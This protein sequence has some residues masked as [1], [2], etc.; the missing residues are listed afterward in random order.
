MLR[1]E[2]I[3]ISVTNR[4]KK[5]FENLG[6]SIKEDKL[7]IKTI[8]LSVNS[9]VNVGVICDVCGKEYSLMYAKYTQNV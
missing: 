9:H 7:I 8:D 5:H 3:E 4:N 6:Y 1:D 2:N